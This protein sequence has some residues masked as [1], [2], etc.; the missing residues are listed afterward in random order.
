MCP[1]YVTSIK[2]CVGILANII[3]LVAEGKTL[4][5]TSLIGSMLGSIL[6]IDVT[7]LLEEILQVFDDKSKA[8]QKVHL[9]HS[10]SLVH[11]TIVLS[12]FC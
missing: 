4:E 12:Q 8:F 11:C 6:E 3:P 2:C 10:K 9:A 7:P 1:H 5:L